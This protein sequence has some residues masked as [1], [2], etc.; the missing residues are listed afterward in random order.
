MSPQIF[1]PLFYQSEIIITS[2]QQLNL[3]AHNLYQ[4]VKPA[5]MKV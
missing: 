1:K 4:K 5:V 3:K 2:L